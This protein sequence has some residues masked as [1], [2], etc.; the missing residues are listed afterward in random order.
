MHDTMEHVIHKLFSLFYPKCF[1]RYDRIRKTWQYGLHGK[2]FTLEDCCIVSIK[3][4]VIILLQSLFKLVT[5]ELKSRPSAFF[6][7]IFFSS[8]HKMFQRCIK[9][10][11]RL[12]KVCSNVS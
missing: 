11:F 7:A 12:L 2:R 5:N 6:M 9:N 4:I 3:T 10:P 8:T 1:E